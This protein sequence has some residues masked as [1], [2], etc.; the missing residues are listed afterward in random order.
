MT[1]GVPL[2]RGEA[3]IVLAPPEDT[4]VEDTAQQRAIRAA[5][6]WSMRNMF[7]FYACVAAVGV[8]AAFFIKSS[9]LSSEHTETRTGL[10]GVEKDSQGV[11]LATR[12]HGLT[13]DV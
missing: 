3:C 10:L 12:R 2:A 7:I 9:K 11:E 13:E 6:A 4:L 8:V 1:A 5:F